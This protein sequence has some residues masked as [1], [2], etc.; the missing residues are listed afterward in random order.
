MQPAIYA[1]LGGFARVWKIAEEA[2]RARSVRNVEMV[3]QRCGEDGEYVMLQAQTLTCIMLTCWCARMRIQLASI[4]AADDFQL[5][6]SFRNPD[7][8][9]EYM[10]SHLLH[11]TF[12]ELLRF[13]A[14]A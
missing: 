5:L 14:D 9:F 12:G 6:L 8:P 4:H 10:Y 11:S 7:G 1:Y 13:C 2:G 3:I